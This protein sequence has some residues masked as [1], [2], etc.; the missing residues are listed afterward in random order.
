MSFWTSLGKEHANVRQFLL[1]VAKFK[2]GGKGVPPASVR[3]QEGEGIGKGT[4]TTTTMAALNFVTMATV[5]AVIA[6]VFV[7][8]GS[9]IGSRRLFIVS[10][11]DGTSCEG[12]DTTIKYR[13]QE[14][15]APKDRRCSF[16][17]T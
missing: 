4:T 15:N 11:I 6:C 8:L 10:V 17:Q 2:A 3:D 5:I 16:R 9:E 7:G 12:G 14:L 1:D 13:Q